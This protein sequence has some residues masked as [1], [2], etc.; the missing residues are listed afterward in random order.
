MVETR[1]KPS[2]AANTKSASAAEAIENVETE[3][4]EAPPTVRKSSRKVKQRGATMVE[5]RDDDAAVQ[6]GREEGE[7]AADVETPGVVVA[8]GQISSSIAP[9]GTPDGKLLCTCSGSSVRILSLAT[10][11][12]VCQLEGHTGRVTGIALNPLNATQLFSCSL[13]GSVRAW[14]VA[15]GVHLETLYQGGALEG[16]HVPSEGPQQGSLLLLARGEFG[17][18]TVLSLNLTTRAA[19][20]LVSKRN[21]PLQLGAGSRHYIGTFHHRVASIYSLDGQREASLP[22]KPYTCMAIDPNE[23]YAAIGDVTGR[24]VLWR[25]FAAN[26]VPRQPSHAARKGGGAAA[27]AHVPTGLLATGARAT[28]G[29]RGA[30][31][32]VGDDMDDVSDH[33]D[34][35]D[36]DEDD[37]DED[38]GGGRSARQAD[39]GVGPT[40]A[41]GGDAGVTSASA[42]GKV[43]TVLH[44]HAQRVNAVVFSADGEYLLSG[45]E[46][47]VLVIWQL[48]SNAKNFLP[49]LGAPILAISATRDPSEF[50]LAL[51][52]NRLLLV[53][54]ATMGVHRAIH[55]IMP[56]WQHP[57]LPLARDMLLVEPRSQL[58][59]LATSANTIQFYDA[60]ADRHVWEV[61]VA[62]RN[63]VSLTTEGLTGRMGA[64]GANATA[65]LTADSSVPRS[66]AHIALVAFSA[67]GDALVTVDVRPMEEPNAVAAAAAGNSY[68]SAP[69]GNGG[70]AV[71]GAGQVVSELA[72]LK[73]WGRSAPNVVDFELNTRVDGPH[74]APVTGLSYHPQEHIA[75]TS[76][77]D[78]LFKVWVRHEHYDGEVRHASWRCRSVG[79]YREDPLWAASF[80]LDGSVL[81]VGAM[82]CVPLWEYE[83]NTLRLVLEPPVRQAPRP[84]SQLAFVPGGPRLVAATGVPPR[85]HGARMRGEKPWTDGGS[86]RDDL[87]VVWNLLTTSVEWAY[88]LHVQD[89]TVDPFSGHRFAIS[90][91][92]PAG[93]GSQHARDGDVSSGSGPHPGWV[94]LFEASSRK[95]VAAWNVN[96]ACSAVRFLAPEAVGLQ[97]D[98]RG[99][100]YSLLVDDRGARPDSVLVAVTEDREVVLVGDHA[101]R[102]DAA[103]SRNALGDASGPPASSYMSLFGPVSQPSRAS[104]HW[105]EPT[106]SKL[107]NRYRVPWGNMLEGPSHVIPSLTRICSSLLDTMLKKN[108]ESV[109]T[110][111]EENE[112]AA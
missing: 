51:D 37:S 88:F 15:S 31:G 2:R 28:E 19:K 106:G 94:I 43:F 102:R 62:P 112:D 39:G 74:K 104:V 90:V 44:W 72:C 78:G 21:C 103:T 66:Q 109:T 61:E 98:M 70:A 68:A 101:Q 26:M 13:D 25:D 105:E 16:M 77:L 50:I 100:R 69:A 84:V 65:A 108:A 54:I 8:G 96:R 58:L 75:V 45:G 73:F 91:S 99:E 71:K 60:G 18:A 41:S 80:S 11:E 64:N 93:D 17:T 4:V 49:R 27:D 42:R 83:T 55:G 79:Y 1:H 67:D 33:D 47:A 23:R 9:I 59:A 57:S 81:A 82:G 76:S 12:L 56:A 46:E 20:A 107:G 7:D 30:D 63:L 53:N 38:G 95:P 29:W 22:H 85:P 32:H 10:G 24:I 14:D 48:Q 34:D 52:E 3:L 5:A 87:L 6:G 97:E 111:Q 89:L 35:D 92:A 40:A 36:D 110:K 86:S